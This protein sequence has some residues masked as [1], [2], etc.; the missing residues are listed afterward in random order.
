MLVLIK[1]HIFLVIAINGLKKELRNR[2]S[3]KNDVIFKRK[4]A[5]SALK[6]CEKCI[7][8]CWCQC[9][10]MFTSFNST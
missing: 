4:V 1:K 3:D 8:S 10:V 9:D 6:K 2:F 5:F 7:L